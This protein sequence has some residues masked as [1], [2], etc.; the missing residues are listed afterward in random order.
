MQPVEPES[1]LPYTDRQIL[2]A[3]EASQKEAE[4]RERRRLEEDEE[5]QRVLQLSLVDK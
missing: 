5:L 3:M 4:E 1:Q 2:L